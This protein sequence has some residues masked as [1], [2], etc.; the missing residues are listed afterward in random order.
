MKA[1][2]LES[3]GN[4]IIR[5]LPTPLCRAGEVLVKVNA[6][7]ICRTDI[8]CMTVGQR[9]L[10]LPRVLGHELAG[11]VVDTGPGVSDVEVGSRVQVFPGIACGSCEYCRK[12]Y[13]NLCPQLQIIG[14]NYDGG[15]QEYIL[16]PEKGVKNGVLNPFPTAITFREAAVVEPLACSI[17]MQDAVRLTAMDTL[18]VFGAGRLGLLNLKLARTRGVEKIIVI[19]TNEIREKQAIKY[20]F[21]YVINPLKTDAT[22]QIREITEGRGVDVVIT[23]CPDPTAMDQGFEM[24]A[25]KGRFGF[26]SGLLMQENTRIDFNK[27]HYRELEVIGAYGCSRSHNKR[28]LEYI[29]GQRVMVNDLIT[30]IIGI[31]EIKK[32]MELFASSPEELIIVVEYPD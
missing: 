27:V 10:V 1:A 5:E 9:D 18:L 14:F 11:T 6:C 25:K 4:L 29:T 32:G 20:G 8:K 31:Q 3:T 22:A 2:V 12:G 16:I 7:G 15:F 24:L 28:A 17:N 23:C 13:E 26:F 30:R 21:N 19:E